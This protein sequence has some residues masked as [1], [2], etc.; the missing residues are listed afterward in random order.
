MKSI[1]KWVV[2]AAALAPA[3]AFAQAQITN[4]DGVTTKFS[5]I[6]NTV[7]T[8]LISLAVI[9]III[10]VVRYLI[11]GAG[12]PASRATAGQAII[13]GIVGLF[14]ILSIWGLVKILTN[15]FRTDTTAPQDQFP[16]V[17]TPPQI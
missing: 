5:N 10:N 6:G 12:D 4:I 2:A 1:M 13:W 11:I 15:S 7:I 9:W 16:K 3:M 14:V 8:I 17:I